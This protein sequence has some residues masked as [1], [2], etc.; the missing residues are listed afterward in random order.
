[1]ASSAIRSNRHTAARRRTRQRRT[2]I[3]AIGAVAVV[4]LAVALVLILTTNGTSPTAVTVSG[5]ARTAMLQTGD[6]IPDF[7]GPGLTGGRVSWKQFEGHPAVVEVWAPWCPH[8]QAELPVMGTV[9]PK[10]PGVKV[11]MIE[12]AMGQEPG[13]SGEGFFMQHHLTFPSAVDDAN[14]TLARAFGVQGFPTVYFVGSDG[15][16]VDSFSGEAPASMLAQKFQELQ[17]LEQ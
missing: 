8:C 16:V 6:K 10:F 9:A 11:V 15:R 13:P 14:G 7:S 12:T 17:S 2:W 3:G 5:P 1:M 4:G